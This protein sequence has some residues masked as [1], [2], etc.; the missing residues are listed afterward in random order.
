[1][2]KLPKIVQIL[3]VLFGGIFGLHH[4]INKDF[5]KGVVYTLTCGLFWFGWL[6]DL[7]QTIVQKKVPD[8]VFS[9]SQNND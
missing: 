8:E 3:I 4:Y 6:Y 9:T 2:E 1:M 7:Y 5:A